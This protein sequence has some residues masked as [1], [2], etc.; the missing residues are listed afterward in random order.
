MGEIEV[1]RT[2]IKLLKNLRMK[3]Q[4]YYISSRKR[5]FLLTIFITTYI[6]GQWWSMDFIEEIIITLYCAF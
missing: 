4:Q 3:L 1:L 6:Y 2:K 5:I